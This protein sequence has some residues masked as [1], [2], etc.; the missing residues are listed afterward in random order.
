M[1]KLLMIVCT[2]KE[3]K[4]AREGGKQGKV[5]KKGKKRDEHT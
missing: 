3:E 4:N 2:Q 5:E 1:T